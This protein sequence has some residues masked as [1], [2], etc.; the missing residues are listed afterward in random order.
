MWKINN[1]FSYNDQPEVEWNWTIKIIL[2]VICLLS[3]SSLVYFYFKS[4][5][6][7]KDVKEPDIY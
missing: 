3:F 7:L 4:F 2:I 6:K 1:M 5:G